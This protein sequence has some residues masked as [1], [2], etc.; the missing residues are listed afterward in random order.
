MIFSERQKS[1]FF[2]GLLT[3]IL[4]LIGVF[5]THEKQLE[6]LELVTYDTLL[7][8]QASVFNPQ[9]VV[10]AIDDASLL[11]LGRWPWSRRRHAELIDRLTD[12]G[13]R[14]I[15][16]DIIFS[17][18]QKDD[19]QA[20]VML[21]KALAKN[22]H[23][24]LVV[25]PIQS[26]PEASVSE[27]LPVPDLALA[28]SVLGHV[29]VEL[30]KDGLCRRYF[31]YAGMSDPHWPALAQ[32]MLI[33]AGDIKSEN[34]EKPSQMSADSWVRQKVTLIPYAKKGLRPTII[35]YTDMLSG[36]VPA[37]AIKN[38]YVLI[39]ATAT[40][41][42]DAISTPASLS[43]ERMPGVELNAHILNG[44]LEGKNI[45]PLPEKQGLMMTAILILLSSII[46]FML[47]LRSGFI[48][49][50]AGI[51][52]TLGISA[53]LLAGMQLWFPPVAA[54]LMIALSWPLWSIWQ[55]GVETR[56]RQNLL[57]R[58]EHQSLHHSA[59][60]LPNMGML[61]EKLRLIN[62]NDD[63][64]SKLAS[65]MVVH[66][67]WS[68]SASITLG[69]PRGDLLLKKIGERLQKVV[70]GNR[71]IAHLNGDDFAILLSGLDNMQ[72]VEFAAVAL[73]K[74]L[75]EPLIQ[76]N[77][78]ILLTPQ[79]GVS[80]WP[81]DGFDGTTLL[82]NAYT[83]MFKSRIDDTESLCIYS[84]DIGQKLQV[85]S[86]LEQALVHALERGEFM[87]FY[88]PQVNARDGSIVGVEALLRWQNP[89]LGWVGP[90][91]FIP[92]AEHVG[93]INVIGKWVLETACQQLKCWVD[94]GFDSLRLAV[95]VSPLQFIVP[96]L[97]SNV[98]RIVEQTGINPAQLEL[99]I[100][101][102]S[103]MH[104]MDNAIQVMQEIQQQGMELAIDDFGTGYSSLSSLRKFPLNRL[105]IDQSFTREIG[106]DVDATEITL[107]ILAMGKQL[108]LSVIAEGIETVE[109][110]DFLRQ[111]GCDEFQGYLYSRPLP[112]E[113]I[114]PLLQNGINIQDND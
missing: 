68:G 104:D 33:A 84:A 86:R 74:K 94:E 58:L 105:K 44:L 23:V 34:H 109:Q 81:D 25:A 46:V 14:S 28:S 95:N 80:V 59:T 79:I 42:G 1:L 18:Y 35:S 27:L 36:Q 72:D 106:E 2:R 13:A 96:G 39:G 75:Q 90:D 12:M 47:Q 88:Q 48:A 10:I 100:T 54:M 6:R 41:L 71:F 93:L 92:V 3:T 52:V 45:Y 87:V 56:L 70:I 65:L 53:F 24:V 76:N 78:E 4:V 98:M 22:K 83:A 89:S 57:K 37:S 38:K 32:A 63:N 9:I 30:D 77:Q 69:R 82:R 67:N 85:R 49:M 64:F 114:L 101:E 11:R 15:G 61:E 62:D 97:A 29:D 99:E 7:P 108:G 112:A 107:T 17:E 8:L 16:I 43:H 19:P 113:Q 111:H 31:L 110:A 26:T 21:A 51:L 66:I 103:L 91:A 20:D 73:L 60:G 5:L 102:S 55:M 50:L 40:G